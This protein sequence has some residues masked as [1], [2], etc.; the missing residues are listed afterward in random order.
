MPAVTRLGDISTG[1]DSWPS[2]PSIS[3]SG[4]VFAEGIPVHRAGDFWAAHCNPA[5]SCHDGVLAAGSG[6]VFVNGRPIGRV[7]DPI[8]CG[9]AVAQGAGTV[10]AN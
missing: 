7:G 2:R 4:N 6:T 8:S 5:R 3:A 10:F 9:D 1:H